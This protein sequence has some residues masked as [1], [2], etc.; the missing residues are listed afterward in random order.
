M[1]SARDKIQTLI[2]KDTDVSDMLDEMVHEEAS[3][4]AS[5]ANND[6]L[7][8]QLEF[9][10]TRGIS[11]ENVLEELREQIKEQANG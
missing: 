6:G 10:E 9:L 5:A 3:E 1:P 2:D 8:S 4:M 11:A 7:K